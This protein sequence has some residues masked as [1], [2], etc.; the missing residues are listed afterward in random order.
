MAQ[1]NAHYDTT[2]YGQAYSH[3]GHYGQYGQGGQGGQGGG[4]YPT[5][6]MSK[7][8]GAT[9]AAAVVTAQLSHCRDGS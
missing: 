9:A 8:P 7:P 3:Y 6:V 2:A 1:G 4:A 5:G